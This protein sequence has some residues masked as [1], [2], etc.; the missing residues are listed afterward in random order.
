MEMAEEPALDCTANLKNSPE[1]NEIVKESDE[2]SANCTKNDVTSSDREHDFCK[3]EPGL[4][5]DAKTT[6]LEINQ[7]SDTVKP[8]AEK[9]INENDKEE[10]N[11]TA[12]LSDSDLTHKDPPIDVSLD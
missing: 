4:N 5:S 10:S 1:T 3:N 12:N 11:P 8:E 9:K 7:E 6:T 2:P